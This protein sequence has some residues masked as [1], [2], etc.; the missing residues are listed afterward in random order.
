MCLYPVKIKNPRYLPNSKNGGY[1]VKCRNKDKEYIDAKCGMCI[2]CR[3]E[4]YNNWRIRLQEELQTDQEEPKFVTFSF[5]PES[6][7]KLCKEF[8]IPECN[9]VAGF[10]IRRFLERWRKTEKKSVKHWFITELGDKYTERIHLHGI[11][12][13]NK[14]D[15]FIREK[16]KYGNIYVG[17]KCDAV[18]IKYISKYM[19]KSDKKHADFKGQIF[20]SPG[21][22]K[23]YL[24]REGYRIHRFK[25]RKTIRTYQEKDGRRTQLPR[26]YRNKCWTQGQRDAMWTWA[27]L[28]Q[29]A[30]C[31]G[32]EFN[33]KNPLDVKDYNAWRETQRQI[34]ERLGYGTSNNGKKTLYNITERMMHW[35]INERGKKEYKGF[36]E[37]DRFAKFKPILPNPDFESQINKDNI[38]RRRNWLKKY[39]IKEISLEIKFNTE[40]KEKKSRGIKQRQKNIAIFAETIQKILPNEN[41]ET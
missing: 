30:Y 15:N 32:R 4:R 35:H 29:K 7:Q 28:D 20:T 31:M 41:N 37:I 26:Y 23:N 1:P 16:W 24:E 14:D 27:I 25:G 12:W 8:E 22:G 39:G 3:K 9:A 33:L 5:S 2:E 34:N 13:T 17:Y 19:L 40:K 18:C 36:E 38:K 6:L 11:L 21:I 10:A